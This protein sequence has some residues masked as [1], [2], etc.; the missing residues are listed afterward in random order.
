MELSRPKAADVARA[1]TNTM[2]DAQRIAFAIEMVRDVT[3]PN[4]SFHLTRLG[5]LAISTS[6]AMT[7]AQFERESA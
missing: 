3:D 6:H 7:K 2:S 1:A 5:N 4:C